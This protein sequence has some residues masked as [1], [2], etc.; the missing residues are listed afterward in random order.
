MVTIGKVRL[1]H[2]TQHTCVGGLSDGEARQQR[3]HTT[4]QTGP[5]NRSPPHNVPPLIDRPEH[6]GFRN[7]LQ[8][9]AGRLPCRA[10]R[11]RA[12]CLIYPISALL[13]RDRKVRS[14]QEEQFPPSSLNVGCRLSTP[15]FDGTHWASSANSAEASDRVQAD[16]ERRAL[17]WQHE[18]RPLI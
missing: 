9:G 12:I 2:E 15:T 3:R 18:R 16:I 8:G 14:E 5:Q 10:Y 4:P 13:V 6:V 7:L 11:H 17:R 1:R